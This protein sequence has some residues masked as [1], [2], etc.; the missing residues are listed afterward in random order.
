[1]T[2]RHHHGHIRRA[3]YGDANAISELRLQAYSEA[4]E[5]TVMDAA[6]LKWSADDEDNVVLAVWDSIGTA[7]S[8]T[9]GDLLF[10]SDEAQLRME[11]ALDGIPIGFPAMQLGKGATRK[12]YGR[13]GFHSA[14]RLCFLDASMQRGVR[15]L[16]GVVYDGAPRTRL[17]RSI[18][19]EFYVPRSYWYQDLDAHRRTLIAVLHNRDFAAASSFLHERVGHV[20][21]DYPCDIHGLARQL[22][23]GFASPTA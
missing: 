8:T 15:T 5:F 23:L 14:L 7:L 12:P 18:G 1:M 9:R 3:T 13:Q 17:M 21:S 19:Y 11:C 20:L 2:D 10:G 22:D 4:P 16:L 6:A